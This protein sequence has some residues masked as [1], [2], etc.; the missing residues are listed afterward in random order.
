MVTEI[1]GNVLH[2]L[3]CGVTETALFP[4]TAVRC[5]VTPFRSIHSHGPPD[6]DLA[7]VGSVIRNHLSVQDGQ[8]QW[9]K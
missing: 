2:G 6:Q 7:I 8:W 9:A 4:P 1:E 3:V 5:Q